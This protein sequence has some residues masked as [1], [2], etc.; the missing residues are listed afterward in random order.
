[1]LIDQELIK[2]FINTGGMNR[3][4]TVFQDLLKDLEALFNNNKF[5]KAFQLI[6]ILQTQ[7]TLFEF[8]I[9]NHFLI[10]RP[11][12]ISD[13]F[14]DFIQKNDNTTKIIIIFVNNLL[15]FIKSISN[16]S[17]S[18]DNNKYFDKLNN[19]ITL[20]IGLIVRI[21]YNSKPIF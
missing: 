3:Y 17:Q 10:D 20:I 9:Q 2:N 7:L 14:I 6:T 19:Y 11:F 1:M 18:Q 4:L 12:T 16:L 8:L 5:E 21:C 13:I 15:D